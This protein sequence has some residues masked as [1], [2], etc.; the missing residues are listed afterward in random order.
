MNTTPDVRTVAPTDPAEVAALLAACAGENAAVVPYGGGTLQAIGN[1][2]IR[3]DV[4]L[5]LR[6]V[7]GI[8]EYDPREM[9]LG[10]AA[11]TTVAEVS[12]VLG[13]ANQFV[14]F[15]VP[16]PERATIGGSLAS[17]WLGPRRA[18]YGRLRDL[19]IGSTAALSDGTLASSGGMVVKNVTGYDV[20]KLYIGSLGTLGV[21]VRANFKALPR[22]P[23]RR[24]AVAPLL[25]DVRER[26]IGLISGLPVEPTALAIIDGFTELSGRLGGETR[27]LAL[28]EGS[29]AVVERATRDLRSALGKAGVAQTTL[30]EGQDAEHTFA[31]FI[32]AYIASVD[33]RSVTYRSLGL[34]G[35]ALVRERR[36]RALA[37]TH[38]VEFDAIVDLRTGD[39]ILRFVAKSP[40]SLLDSIAGLD[41]E[42]HSTLERCVIIAG[43]P[44]ARARV[45][46]WGPAPSTIATMRDLKA[47]FDRAGI[48]AP[49]RFVG[50]I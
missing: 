22:P 13:T 1:A 23:V 27:M 18:S 28:F 36:A 7:S 38:G 4:A 6:G 15:D 8:R 35:T 5:D 24:L 40:Q 42:L 21:I 2:P 10:I 37:S 48:L 45:D 30:L 33:E 11:G 16:H 47:R 14:P 12:R 41:T 34:P 9:T 39:V 49:G 43:A 3:C 31:R 19:V 20:S 44:H 50:G 32:D 25:S 17:G 46:A 26:A 29:E